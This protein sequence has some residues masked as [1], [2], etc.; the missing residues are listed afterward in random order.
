MNI[1]TP[2]LTKMTPKLSTVP[3]CPMK[4]RLC[5]RRTRS[6]SYAN[7]PVDRTKKSHFQ[8]HLADMPKQQGSET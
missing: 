4:H 1:I 8:L 2:K 3:V 7:P 6:P 5:K